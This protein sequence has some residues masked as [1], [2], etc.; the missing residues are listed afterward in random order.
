MSW[1][2]AGGSGAVGDYRKLQVW[3]QSHRLTL[4]VCSVTTSFPKEE[5][6]RLTDQLCR[7][8][9]SIPANIAEGCG[10]NGDSEFARF[11]DIA[12]GS[13]SELDYH[14]ILAATSVPFRRPNTNA[15]RPKS[16]PAPA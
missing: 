11:L 5:T 16:T 2:S 8:V 7:A 9:S 10:R 15:W 13:A 1:S 4:E 3:E 6:Y 12:K 14:L